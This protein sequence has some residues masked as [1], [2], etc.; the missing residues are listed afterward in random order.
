MYHSYYKQYCAVFP[1]F[2]KRSLPEFEYLALQALL[3]CSHGIF[4]SFL[5]FLVRCTFFRDK[6]TQIDSLLANFLTSDALPPTDDMPTVADVVELSPTLSRIR[7]RVLAELHVFYTRRCGLPD[8]AQR[9]GE[10]L[11]MMTVIMVS[12]AFFSFSLLE[13]IYI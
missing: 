9:L 1:D 2:M 13:V 4:S 12:T 3:M 8:Y 10:L 11:S 7:S 5:V 6:K